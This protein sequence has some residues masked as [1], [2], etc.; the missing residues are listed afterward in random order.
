[1]SNYD[2]G[3]RWI[4]FY[5]SER[6]EMHLSFCWL[7]EIDEYWGHP[8]SERGYRTENEAIA[9]MRDADLPSEVRAALK[10]L[11]DN[12]GYSYRGILDEL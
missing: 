6:D 2:S 1:M 8:L 7:Y 9:A 5:C 3:Q 4:P 12:E 11:C 10:T